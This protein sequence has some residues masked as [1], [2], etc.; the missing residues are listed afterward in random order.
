MAIQPEFILVFSL[1]T[2]AVISVFGSLTIGIIN[3][4]SEKGGIKYIPLLLITSYTIY[5]VVSILLE[6][7]FS[8]MV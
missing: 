7:S 8:S 6:N 5:F 2:L 3:S 4:R 1:V